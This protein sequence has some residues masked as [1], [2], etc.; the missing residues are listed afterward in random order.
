[1]TAAVPFC[2]AHALVVVVGAAVVVGA[3]VV[4]VATVVAT[5]MVVTTAVVDGAVVLGA[6]VVTGVV[7][8]LVPGPAVVSDEILLELHA[9]TSTSPLRRM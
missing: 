8:V 4:V 6:A 1:M 2:G 3:S 5:D 7:V 9:A